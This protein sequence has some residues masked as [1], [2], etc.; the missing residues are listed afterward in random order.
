MQ[1]VPL[2][3]EIILGGGRILILRSLGGGGI[4]YQLVSDQKAIMGPGP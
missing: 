2:V 3:S 4:G 1:E